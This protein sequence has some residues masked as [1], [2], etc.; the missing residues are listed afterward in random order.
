MSGNTFGSHFKVM[1]YGESHGRAIGVVIDGCPAGLTVKQEEIQVDLDRR[2]PGQSAIVTQRKEGDHVEI[3]SGVFEGRSTGTPISMIIYNQDQRSKDYGHI[4]EKYRPSHADFTYQEKFGH[5]DYRGGGRSSARET[6]ARVAAGAIAKALLKTQGIQ[7][8]GYVSQVGHLKLDKSHTE[9]D[10]H[11]IEENVIR[12]PDAEL[13][14]QMEAFIR[15]VRKDGDTVGG[16][17]TGVVTGCPVGLGAPAF[18]KLHADLGKAM[19]SI[20]ACKGFEYGS[21]F[22][23][24]TWRGSRHNDIFEKIGDKI[25]TTTNHSGGIQGGIS[26]GMDIYFRVAFKPVATIMQSQPS[27]DQSGKETTV[28]GKGRHDPCVVP[29]AVAIVEAMAAL[30][31]ADHLLRSRSDKI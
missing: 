26:N 23:G 5:R 29:R 22:Q 15:E 17:V 25:V 20:N 6:A 24:V 11:I 14:R 31:L 1:T 21:G 19:L 10:R 28:D 12:C 27:V 30:V 16:V 9:I 2:R 8:F 7:V 13:A 3:L 18:D 4:A